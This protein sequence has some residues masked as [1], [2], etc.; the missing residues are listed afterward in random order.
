MVPF[1][2]FS[3]FAGRQQQPRTVATTTSFKDA[4]GGLVTSSVSL[5]PASQGKPSPENLRR[6]GREANQETP[7]LGCDLGADLERTGYTWGELERLAQQDHD[8]W[9]VLIGGL[10]PRPGYR[11]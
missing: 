4:G 3:R 8:G 9:R 2:G 11:R 10:C 5:H 1:N 6:K 7:G